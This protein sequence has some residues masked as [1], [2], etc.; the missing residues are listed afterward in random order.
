MTERQLKQMREDAKYDSSKWEYT[1]KHLYD[2]FIGK[3]DDPH[4]ATK[5][6]TGFAFSPERESR[7]LM[8][9]DF[10]SGNI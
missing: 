9:N 7:K 1:S 6:I 5:G 8:M 2:K 10:K 3:L 4:I